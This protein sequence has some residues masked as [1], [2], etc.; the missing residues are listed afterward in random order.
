MSAANRPSWAKRAGVLALNLA[1]LYIAWAGVVQGQAWGANLLKFVLWVAGVMGVLAI[2]IADEMRERGA[3][4]LPR[5]LPEWLDNAM[6]LAMIGGLAAYGWFGYATL[7][8]LCWFGELMA[9]YDPDT[10]P[11]TEEA[12][13]A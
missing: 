4:P 7:A 2:L 3:F 8:L 6:S 10:T 1:I 5:S 13:H 12:T 9:H 11:A